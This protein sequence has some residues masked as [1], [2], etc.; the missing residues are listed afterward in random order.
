MNKLVTL[1]LVERLKISDLILETKMAE[2]N[3]NKKS[4]TTI[5]TR[6]SVNNLFY[7]GDK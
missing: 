7:L 6:C 1:A 2:L 4:K 5:L 3:Q